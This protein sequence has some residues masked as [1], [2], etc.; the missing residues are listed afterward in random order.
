MNLVAKKYARALRESFGADLERALKALERMCALYTSAE[1]IEVLQSPYYPNTIKQ[2]I[3]NDVLEDKDPRL[4]R[5][6]EVLSEHQRFIVLPE[7]YKELCAWVQRQQNAYK[8]YLF[9]NQ[10]V[11]DLGM[12]EAQVAKRLNITLSLESVL[13]EHEGIRLEIP[14]LGVEVAFYKDHF[15][16]QLKH[17]IMEAV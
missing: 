15:F 5:F 17:F 12:L 7:I 9:C 16:R 3:L 14:D 11:G 4:Q 1:F 13:V 10:E 6:L 8:G 2:K